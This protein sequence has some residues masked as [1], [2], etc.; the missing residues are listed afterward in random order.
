M[1]TKIERYTNTGPVP[2]GYS[3]NPRFFHGV[4]IQPATSR[5]GAVL[6]LV[7]D[8]WGCNYSV[9]NCPDGENFTVVWLTA[10]ASDEDLEKIRELLEGDC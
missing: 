7:G 6:D 9:T 4:K 8:S 10:I 1:A 2:E 5:A 3:R